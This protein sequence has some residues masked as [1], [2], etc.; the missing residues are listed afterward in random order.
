MTGWKAFEDQADRLA[1]MNNGTNTQQEI[2]ILLSDEFASN[3]RD[4]ALEYQIWALRTARTEKVAQQF[5]KEHPPLGVEPGSG[6]ITL[7]A[8]EGDPE[9]DFL[10]ILDEVE[11]HHGMAS[12]E[13]PVV[14][15]L[16]VLGTPA[17]ETIRDALWAQGFTRIESR[18][19]GFL[20]RWHRE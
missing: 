19:D 7:F 9:R 12:R 17:S 16:W 8:G 18:P 15:V 14:S 1:P 11:L 10:S 13:H 20:A 3:M 2:I 6:G 5:W 4:L